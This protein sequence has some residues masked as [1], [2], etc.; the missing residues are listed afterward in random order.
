MDDD[1][2]RLRQLLL[3][4]EQQRL[5]KLEDRVTDPKQRSRD[6]ASVLPHALQQ[7]NT[8]HGEKLN[9][10]LQ[11]PVA[12]CLQHSIENNPQNLAKP[13]AKPL[14]SLMSNP[15]RKLLAESLKSIREFSHAQQQQLDSLE[16]RLADNAGQ[17]QQSLQALQAH[18]LQLQKAVKTLEQ[19]LDDAELRRRELAEILPDIIRE[20]SLQNQPPMLS[21]QK[22]DELTDSLRL[23]VERCLQESITQNTETL[24]NALFPVMGPAI[25]RSINESL[26]ALV[27]QINDTIERNA[28]LRGVMWRLQARRTGRS[29]AEVMLQNTLVYRVEQIFLIHRETGLLIQHMYQQDIEV[30][31]SDA[32]SAMF[33]AIQDFTR[34]S[35]SSDKTEE[36]DSVE[37][38]NFIVWL[39]RGP[40]AV[41]ACVIRGVAPYEFRQSMRQQLE[42][43]HARFNRALQNYEGDP[44]L[45]DG[46]QPML[47][48]LLKSE[49]KPKEQ[50]RKQ[51]VLSPGLIA[52]IL[53]CSAGVLYWGYSSWQEWSRHQEFKRYLG[54]LWSTPGV[55]VTSADLGDKLYLQGLRDPLA[56][57]PEQLRE[58]LNLNSELVVADWRPYQDL[59]PHFVQRRLQQRLTRWLQAPD[60]VKLY[61]DGALLRVSGHADLKWIE[62]L[63]SSKALFTDLQ[64]ID[65][66]QLQDS[67]LQLKAFIQVLR[68]TPGLVVVSTDLD[69]NPPQLNGLRDPLAADPDVLAAEMNMVQLQMSWKPYQAL[70]PEFVEKR[71]RLALQPPETVQLS[72]QDEV[73]YLGGYAPEEWIARAQSFR[74]IG[75]TRVDLEKL[76]STSQYLLK[77]A[78]QVLQPS[79]ALQ[80]QVKADAELWLSGETDAEEI[81]RIQQHMPQL[82]DFFVKINN[83][84][85]DKA[86]RQ[87]VELKNLIEKQIVYFSDDITLSTE[88][89][90]N[91]ETLGQRIKQ[92][93]ALS[94]EPSTIQIQCIGHTDGLGSKQHNEELGQ[95]RAR[96]VCDRLIEAGLPFGAFQAL[97]GSDIRYGESRMNPQLR[98][99]RIGVQC[100]PVELCQLPH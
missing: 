76:Q 52:I 6:V 14:L 17:Q 53:L 49:A 66:S 81:A 55:I 46:S 77:Q 97:A 74:M 2:K 61:W 21:A 94:P 90:N 100:K 42:A 84:V 12:D 32:V 83:Q 54:I 33:T 98:H 96:Y 18:N 27:Q 19:R 38:G 44:S 82:S 28:S 89:Q 95:Q 25:R 16:V 41:L 37:I 45:L 86:Y 88:Q 24:A 43:I 5:A 39:E 71:A 47:S 67:N 1:Y 3:E 87:R 63:H 51:R 70:L 48:K 92:L 23:P 80:L 26:K 72:L 73:L 34:D 8:H 91:I 22:S 13:L 15:L 60:S 35:F 56:S 99:V 65:D 11:G 79:A 20:A 62:H 75:I 57:D 10:A 7:A 64:G 68:D 78:K 30:G 50:A 58:E 31:D 69:A 29:F 59:S 36:L 40:Y 93:L 85:T 4:E 9:A